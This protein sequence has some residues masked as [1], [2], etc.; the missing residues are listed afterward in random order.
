M[1]N[2]YLKMS[3][4]LARITNNPP[5]VLE[6]HFSPAQWASLDPNKQKHVQSYNNRAY[7]PKD[8]K[9]CLNQF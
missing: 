4:F 8:N 1:Q 9:Q 7:H 2:F 5:T 3:T 6:F